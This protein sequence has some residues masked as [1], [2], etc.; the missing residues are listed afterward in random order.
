M[1]NKEKSTI[2]NS[3]GKETGTQ[4]NGLEQKEEINIQPEHK[5]ETRIQKIEETL[6]NIWDN[7]KCSNIYIRGARRRRT[8]ARNWKLIW[9]N[10]EGILPQ[11]GKGTRHA[12]PGSSESPKEV[13]SKEKHTKTHPNYISQ[14]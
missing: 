11:S 12:S 14:D 4:I 1:W 9:K 13:E 8:I 10:N 7:L 6:R 2:T 3:N 5:E